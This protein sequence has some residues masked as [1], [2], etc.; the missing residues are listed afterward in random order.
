VFYISYM[1]KAI[2]NLKL[3]TSQGNHNQLTKLQK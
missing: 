1:I 3:F 2:T